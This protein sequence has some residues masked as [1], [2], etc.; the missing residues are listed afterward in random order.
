VR[1]SRPGWRPRR[2]Q[3]PVEL[4]MVSAAIPVRSKTWTEDP[5][6]LTT[7]SDYNRIR[8]GP[9]PGDALVTAAP[10]ERLFRQPGPIRPALADQARRVS[11][12]G[13]QASESD[14][15]SCHRRA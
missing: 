10:G 9:I 1:Q 7:N 4:S 3:P 13:N 5:K 11:V 6:A 12:D 14:S 15:A 2:A 8:H